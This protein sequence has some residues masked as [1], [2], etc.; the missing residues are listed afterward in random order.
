VR[1]HGLRHSAATH[2][3]RNASL[4][5]LKRLGGWTTLSSPSRYLDRDDKDRR[6]ALAVVEC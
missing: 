4:A 6:T 1:P 2:C 3:A 5:A